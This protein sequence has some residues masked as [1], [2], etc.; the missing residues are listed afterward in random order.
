MIRVK[1]DSRYGAS[2]IGSFSRPNHSAMLNV[3][4]CIR[5]WVQSLAV[6]SKSVLLA[7]VEQ[8]MDLVPAVV[9]VEAL[10]WGV[11][12][13]LYLLDGDWNCVVSIFEV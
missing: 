1:H 9:H 6:E 5:S 7:P 3:L 13:P 11:S 12:Q 4:L 2:T 8:T 10:V